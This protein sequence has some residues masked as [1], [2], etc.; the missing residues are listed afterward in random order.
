[1]QTLPNAN[2]KYVKRLTN[3]EHLL[4]NSNDSVYEVFSTEGRLTY[5]PDT[6]KLSWRNTT[7][8]YV[9]D[10]HPITPLHNAIMTVNRL[11]IAQAR[12][13]V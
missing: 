1:M 12:Q 11:T 6:K 10:L 4:Y 2:Y 13:Q 8:C 3:N 7:L 9:R 5:F